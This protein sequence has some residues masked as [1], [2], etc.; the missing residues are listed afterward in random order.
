MVRP[1]LEY[2]VQAWS[3]FLDGD[4]K[5]IEEFQERATQIP[6]GFSELEYEE[7]LTRLNL[8]ALKDRRIKGDII[9]I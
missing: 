9:E 3:P 2:A 8:T 5:K 4:I 1:H 6:Y 7:R